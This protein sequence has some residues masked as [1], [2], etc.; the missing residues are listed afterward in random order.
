MLRILSVLLA[1]AVTLSACAPAAPRLGADGKP[2][3]KAYRISRSDTGKIQFRMLDS[4][5]ALRQASGRA[6]VQLNP[7]LNAAAATHSRDMSVQNRPWHFGSDGSSPIDRINRVGYAGKLVGETISET[8]E[9]ELE[10]L[11]AWMDQP[12]TRRVIMSEEAR[13]M[14]FAWFQEAGGKIWW[15]LVMGN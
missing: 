8:Y 14:G 5:N 15:T 2:L 6:A 12:D 9:S 10:T 7:Q 11:A 1:L 4:V 13:N 3:P